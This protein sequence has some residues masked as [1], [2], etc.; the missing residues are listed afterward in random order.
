VENTANQ[1][2]HFPRIVEISKQKKPFKINAKD[3]VF[4]KP[5][6]AL[7]RNYAPAEQSGKLLFKI[8]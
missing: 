1:T 2:D 5:L 8:R 7:T 3:P 6:S 4:D